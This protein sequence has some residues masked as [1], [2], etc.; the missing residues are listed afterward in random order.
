MERDGREGLKYLAT[1]LV[2]PMLLAPRNRRPL[3]HRRPT[4][5]KPDTGVSVTQM[6]IY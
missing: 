2:M 5:S 1:S 3:E 6:K 4:I